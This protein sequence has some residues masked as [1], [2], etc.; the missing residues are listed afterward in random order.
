LNDDFIHLESAFLYQ[1]AELYRRKEEGIYIVLLQEIVARPTTEK[2]LRDLLEVAGNIETDGGH[3]WMDVLRRLGDLLTSECRYDDAIALY[4][5]AIRQKPNRQPLISLSLGAVH[6][7]RED[8]INSLPILHEIIDKR[9]EKFQLSWHFS[10]RYI[11]KNDYDAGVFRLFESG[12]SQFHSDI[13]REMAWSN[14]YAAGG[15]YGSAISSYMQSVM[16]DHWRRKEWW[17]ASE[18]LVAELEKPLDSKKRST[19]D[20]GNGLN[21]YGLRIPLLMTVGYRSRA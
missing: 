13:P 1:L 3:T 7:S 8:G 4:N 21:G 12:L 2:E 15:K 5:A 16:T 11:A 14:F 6:I 10:L 17:S 19:D 9:P 18:T 20:L